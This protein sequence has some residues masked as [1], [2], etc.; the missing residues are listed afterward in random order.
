[1]QQQVKISNLLLHA[2]LVGKQKHTSICFHAC[3]RE[4]MNCRL[5]KLPASSQEKSTDEEIQGF[6][7]FLLVENQNQAC[8]EV[9]D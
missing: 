8:S 1:M 5:D 2:E 4:G 3:E 9:E 7:S 6:A